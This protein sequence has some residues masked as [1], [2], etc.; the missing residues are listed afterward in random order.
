MCPCS[1]EHRPLG[2]QLPCA[3][4]AHRDP[5]HHCHGAG[6]CA[7]CACQCARGRVH[8]A[9]CARGCPGQVSV[10]T[11]VCPYACTCVHPCAH[12]SAP[13]SQP[14]S[15][16]GQGLLSA[17]RVWLWWPPRAVS[18]GTGLG[19]PQHLV[20]TCRG[21]P[22]RPSGGQVPPGP[23]D[24]DLV[25]RG[26]LRTQTDACSG[27]PATLSMESTQTS[28]HGRGHPVPASLT[29]HARLLSACGLHPLRMAQ[30][31]GA[32]QGEGSPKASAGGPGKGLPPSPDPHTTENPNGAE[33]LAPAMPG[34][35]PPRRGGSSS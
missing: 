25:G 2:P 33:T 17:I 13:L 31:W 9:R 12:V 27:F 28:R 7:L 35:S 21:R 3:L 6:P 14:L 24:W 20:S 30:A 26:F 22:S 19:L 10:C 4:R 16:P 23:E 29:N 18:A 32:E 1:A 15:A 11:C 8:V 34:P 5:R